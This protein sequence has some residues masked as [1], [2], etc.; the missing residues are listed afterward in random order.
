MLILRKVVGDAHA[1]VGHV[2]AVLHAAGFL[3]HLLIDAPHAAVDGFGVAAPAD[4]GVQFCDVHAFA[5]K[6]IHDALFAVIVLVPVGGELF[7]LLRRVGN[8][9]GKNAHVVLKI[10]NLGGRGTKIDDPE[11]LHGVPSCFILR[12]SCFTIRTYYSTRP[13]KFNSFFQKRGIC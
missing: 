1:Q 2:I 9:I 6:K 12:N 4:E 10:G 7:D 11:L 3:Q 13:T 5:F 8:G